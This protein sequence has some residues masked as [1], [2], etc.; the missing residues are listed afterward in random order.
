MPGWTIT[1]GKSYVAET[2][3]STNAADS[4]NAAESAELKRVVGD[5]A[6][7]LIEPGGA[8]FSMSDAS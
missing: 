1:G 4:T 6:R 8:N 5:K 2:G 3:K 7:Y